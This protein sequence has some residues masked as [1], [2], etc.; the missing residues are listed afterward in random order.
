MPV[1]VA[2][3]P[4]T[5][6]LGRTFEEAP[7]SLPPGATSAVA[8]AERTTH[9]KWWREALT[10]A[11]FYE[12][13]SLARNTQGSASTSPEHA[14]RN[15]RAVIRIEQAM[16]LYH[17]Q[18]IQMFFLHAP[19]VVKV[20]NIYYGAAHFFVTTGVMIY[21]YLRHPD[22]YV[23]WRWIL[24]AT[25]AL[26]LIGFITFPVMPPRL[27]TSDFGQS[28]FVDTLHTIGGL[29]SFE[30]G[31]IAKLSN[32]YAAMPSLHFA[33]SVWCAL[34]LWPRL[35]HRASRTLAV[36]HPTITLIG[37]VAT[38]NHFWLDA[39]AGLLVLG[40]GYVA[41]SWL[42]T[43]VGSWHREREAARVERRRPR[44]TVPPD[45]TMETADG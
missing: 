2:H 6:G 7:L 41:G 40:V 33:W 28:G 17:E 13:Y 9:T 21:L 23:R 34:A 27:I 10:I 8:V 39:A 38:A 18:S 3:G 37:I 24:G 20:L 42:A 36:A 15:A 45:E 29:W 19:A 12:V 43:N 22:R 5:Y 44:Q 30:S 4:V 26:A 35:R 25:T 1:L 16:G 32:Q 14:F 31:P 11:L